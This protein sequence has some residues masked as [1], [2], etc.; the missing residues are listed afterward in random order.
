M[1]PPTAPTVL[2]PKPRRSAWG[3]V[4]SVL[5][6]LSLVFL[7]LFFRWRDIMGWD[8]VS[9]SGDPSKRRGGGGGGGSIQAVALP[10]YSRPARAAVE[11]K[12]V[13]PPPPPV[14][15]VPEAQVV[16]PPP[17]PPTPEAVAISAPPDS[18]PASPSAGEG[19]TGT[20]GGKGTGTGPGTGSGTGPGSGSGSG[21]GSGGDGGRAFPPEPRQVI[22]PPMDYPKSLRGKTVAVT[23]WVGT[24]GRVQAVSTAPEISD[25]GFAK[26]FEDVMKNY[27]FRPAR[28]PEGTVIAG[29]TTVTITF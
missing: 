18:I 13:P 8:E 16:V 20:G 7:I 28:S 21:P 4:V 26:K 9:Q 15:P 25:G 29:T 14:V 22:L 17:P 19:G 27:R 23:F 3:G 2:F 12:V 10:A 1:L 11:L 24:D 5:L 6:H